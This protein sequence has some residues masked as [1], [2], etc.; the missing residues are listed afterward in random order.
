MSES[1]LVRQKN[2]LPRNPHHLAHNL[3]RLFNVMQNS[4][5]KH[6]VEAPVCERQSLADPLHDQTWRYGIHMDCLINQ[7]GNGLDPLHKGSRSP[8]QEILH[9]SPGSATNI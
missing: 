4:A 9:A 1:I 6:R 5:L 2:S 3:V 8:L 7:R